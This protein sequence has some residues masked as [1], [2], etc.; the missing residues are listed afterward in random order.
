MYT[1]THVHTGIKTLFA[2][3]SCCDLVPAQILGYVNPLLSP[4][5]PP[6]FSQYLSPLNNHPAL[7]LSFLPRCL[8]L[9]LLTLSPN[10]FSF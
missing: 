4:L 9:N 2:G 1:C 6:Y 10:L 8:F 5:F 3:S 7:H